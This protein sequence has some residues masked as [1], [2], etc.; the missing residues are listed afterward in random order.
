M[1]M[2]E[3]SYLAKYLRISEDDD[4][5]GESRRESNSILNQRKMLDS[6]IAAHDE[7]S[8]YPVREFID[9]GVSGVSF[10]RPGVRSL[11]EEVR[12]YKVCC[13]VV[14]DLSR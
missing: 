4:D 1:A 10:Q 13:I 14:K 2:Y 8:K 7:L 9:D 3:I 6:Y 11:L 5:M 12:R